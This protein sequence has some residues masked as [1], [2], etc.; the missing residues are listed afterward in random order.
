M[1]PVHAFPGA[2]L[3]CAIWLSIVP[4]AGPAAA[5]G[6]PIQV[7]LCSRNYPD[8]PPVTGLLK[9]IDE[10]NFVLLTRAGEQSFNRA[11]FI[12]C[13]SQGGNSPPQCQGGQVATA[14]GCACPANLTVSDGRCVPAP[15]IDDRATLT[16]CKSAETLAIQ[17]SSTVGLGVMPALIQGFANVAGLKVAR[18]ADDVT[19]AVYQLSPADP[20]GRCFVITVLSTGSNTAKEG[21][22]ENIARIGMSSRYYQDDE[23]A[24]LARAANLRGFERSQ[25]EHVVA[26]D[27]VGIVV[28]RRNRI[29]SLEL[30]QI[31]QVFAG[32]ISNWGTFKATPGPIHVHVRTGTSGTSA[33]SGT[34]DAFNALVM[35]ACK[36]T[37]AQAPSHSTYPDLLQAVAV[38]ETSIGFAPLGLVDDSVKVLRLRA[39]CGI[40]QTATPFN[41]KSEDYPLAR[42]L[43][44]LTP[45]A[46]EGYSRQF[47]NFILTDD[48]VDDVIYRQSDAFD[49]KIQAQFDDHASSVNTPETAADPASRARFNVIARSS[50]RLSIT[51]RFA[52]GSE[53]LDSKAR[54]DIRRLAV[55]LRNT[56]PPLTAYLAGFADSGGGISLNLELAAR[57]AD[58]VRRELLAVAPDLAGSIQA[59]GFGKILPVDCNDTQLGREKNRR[60][61]VFVSP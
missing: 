16:P 26:L 35:D 59:R 60:V 38:D 61:E 9:S 18:S 45:F 12:S 17:G 4:G 32:R 10:K 46:L 2:I 41:V 28:N 34:F 36:V 55:Y 15:P 52:L 19:R 21:L 56:K 11:D 39:A 8:F 57:R 23:I 3:L 22:T 40:E 54:E 5:E 6:P 24:L 51:Y 31:A 53:E 20:N 47:E 37:L 33:A 29:E 49:Q 7:R 30:C 50:R 25:I 42:R 58:A 1:K 27:A 44:L 43:Y 14:N 13:P 48:R